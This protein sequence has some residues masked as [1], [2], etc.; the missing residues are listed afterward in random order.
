MRNS[1]IY[2]YVL[3]IMVFLSSCGSGGETLNF[4]NIGETSNVRDVITGKWKFT[5]RKVEGKKIALKDCEQD[6]TLSIQGDGAYVADNGLT[7]CEDTE[8]NDVGTWSLS[9]DDREL[10][11]A[12]NETTKVIRLKGI[13]KTE[14][15]IETSITQDGKT[16]TEIHTYTKIQ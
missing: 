8:A 6:N 2:L 1:Q 14:F 9:D 12:G 5:S 3:G 7:Q 11:F 10:T 16:Q 13:S 15:L 4:A